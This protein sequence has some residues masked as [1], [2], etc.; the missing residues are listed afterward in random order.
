VSTVDVFRVRIRQLKLHFV[1]LPADGPS[2]SIDYS[3]IVILFIMIKGRLFYDHLTI[4][5]IQMCRTPVFPIIKTNFPSWGQTDRQMVHS[6]YTSEGT[7]NSYQCQIV[8][9]IQP[10]Y[11]NLFL[12]CLIFYIKQ[13]IT[14][15]SKLCQ[16]QS[17]STIPILKA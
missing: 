12:Q 16:R 10:M 3:Q 2:L 7:K 14:K 13:I 17:N 1:P 5:A 8:L 4:L 15:T 6:L 11:M 9:Y